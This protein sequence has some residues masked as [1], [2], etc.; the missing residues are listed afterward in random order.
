MRP[1][2]CGRELFMTEKTPEEMRAL[3]T[4]NLKDKEDALEL[5][6]M[7]QKAGSIRVGSKIPKASKAVDDARQKLADHNAKFPSA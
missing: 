2:L 7:A 1:E 4:K 3:L 6:R 5:A